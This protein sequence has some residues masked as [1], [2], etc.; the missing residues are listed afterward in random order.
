VNL[1]DLARR[2]HRKTP[3]KIVLAVADGL[4]GL[5]MNAD[6]QTELEAARTQ[7][8]DALAREG[9]T[10]LLHP[11]RRGITCGS[12]PGHLALFGYDPTKFIVGR[13]VLTALG[14]GFKL[15]SGDVAARG[16]FCTVD[17]NGKVTDRRAGRIADGIGE[18][19]VEKLQT[20]NVS[21]V[22]NS[23]VEIIV[24]HV[25]EYRFVVIFRGPNLGGAIG[26][27]DPRASDTKPHEPVANDPASEATRQAVKA[28]VDQARE[29]LLNESPANMVLLRGFAKRPDLPSLAALY[30]LSPC[31]IAC[32]PMYRGLSRLLEMHVPEQPENLAQQVEQ[33]R[34]LWDD[35][36]FFFLHHKPTD[37]SGEDGD[38]DKK[39]AE[40][41]QFDQQISAIRELNPDVLV[42]TGDHSTPAKLK[43]HSWHPVPVVLH[44]SNCLP[45]RTR[46]FGEREAIAGGLGQFPATE[47]MP[48]MIA[49][50]GKFDKFGA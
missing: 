41:E 28:F 32:Y 3:S 15:R 44:A 42:V 20:I 31:A 9:T 17:H 46:C 26:D 6:G 2:L 43:S 18:R 5:P 35:H 34:R 33:L 49:H 30:G 23:D 24:Q 37:S 19:L 16:N 39:I 29:L 12:G 7:N 13:G 21:A 4:G 1:H 10:G 45:D 11:V 47:L 36:D 40:I 50:A 25:K 14:V 27:T 8:L 22:E 48:L 38:F